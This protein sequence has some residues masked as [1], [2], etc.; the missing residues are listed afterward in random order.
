VC[1]LDHLDCGGKCIP[2]QY[3]GGGQGCCSN[4]DCDGGTFCCD[5]VNAFTCDP[6]ISCG[7]RHH[8][9]ACL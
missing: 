6:H 5:S 1:P 8:C 3:P 9:L 4:K 7:P 2:K